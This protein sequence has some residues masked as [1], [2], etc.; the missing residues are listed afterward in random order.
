MRYDKTLPHLRVLQVNV[1][2]SPSPHGAAL[3]LAFEQDYHAVLIQQPWISNFRERRLSKH[4]PAFHLF[5]PIEYWT[6]RPR[7]LTYICKHPQ[8]KAELVPHGPQRCR[9]LTAVQS[10]PV[11]PCLIAGDFNLRHPQWRTNTTITSPGAVPFLQWAD[12][13][14][15]HLTLQPNT[16]TRGNSTIDLAWANSPLICQGTHTEPAPGFPALTDHIALSTSIHWHP[17][18]NAKPVPPLRMATLQEDIFLSAIRKESGFLGGSPPPQPGLALETL[19]KYTTAIIQAITN[20]LEASTKRAYPHPSG[21]RWWNKECQEAVLAL[22][23][24]SQDPDSPSTEHEM[25]Q[26]NFRRTTRQAKR[27][28]W[29][30]QLDSFTDSQDVFR[31]RF[32]RL[33]FHCLVLV[34]S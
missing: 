14:G 23:K 24:A 21:H 15:L 6:H 29:R 9:D 25:A 32:L 28:Y 8:L 20:A 10:L 4:H 33:S 1:A 18:N 31:G 7:T 26:R 17:V 2:R 12:Q 3:Q 30:I 16:P 27:Q 13:Q 5:T 34:C 19:D 11:G 22:Q